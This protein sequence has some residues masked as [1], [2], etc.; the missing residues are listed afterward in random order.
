MN[1]KITLSIY[2]QRVINYQFCLVFINLFAYI[3]FLLRRFFFFFSS[4]RLHTSC[5][6]VTGCQTCA[7]PIWSGGLEVLLKEANN[8]FAGQAMD[9]RRKRFVTATGFRE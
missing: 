6:L 4:I 3:C 9:K 1:M 8:L 7:L 2:Y 5:A